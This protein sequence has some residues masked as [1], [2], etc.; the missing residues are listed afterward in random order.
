MEDFLPPPA[1]LCF[2]YGRL[3]AAAAAAAVIIA[4]TAAATEEAVAA[5]APDQHD[6]QNDDPP[7]VLA[8][9]SRISVTHKIFPP[10]SDFITSYGGTR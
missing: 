9:H 3:S 7:V 5:A 1:S 4:V 8:A 6:N 10:I 2:S